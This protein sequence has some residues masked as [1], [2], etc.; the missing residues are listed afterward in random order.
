MDTSQVVD[1]GPIKL[2]RDGKSIQVL[3]RYGEEAIG[4]LEH[5]LDVGDWETIVLLVSSRKTPV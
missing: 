1:L 3:D 4:Y 5:V 2:E